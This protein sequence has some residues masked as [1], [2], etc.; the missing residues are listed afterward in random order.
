MAFTDGWDVVSDGGLVKNNVF[1]LI[2]H[3]S[4]QSGLFKNENRRL[5]LALFALIYI[6]ILAISTSYFTILNNSSLI[7]YSFILFILLAV[8]LAVKQGYIS[9]ALLVAIVF[10]AASSV[11][12]TNLL[13]NYVYL[14]AALAVIISALVAAAR[15]NARHKAYAVLF[16][17]LLIVLYGLKLQKL[18]AIDANFAIIGY[19]LLISAVL[20]M[21][22][23]NIDAGERFHGARVWLDSH[24][25]ALWRNNLSV[26]ILLILGII[27]LLL[28]I[29]YAGTRLAPIPL[30]SLPYANLSLYNVSGSGIYL[31]Q[32]NATDYAYLLNANMSNMGFYAIPYAGSEPQHISAFIVKNSTYSAEVP[33]LLKLNSSYYSY[34]IYFMPLEI[35]FENSTYGSVAALNRSA[36]GQIEERAVYIRYS[37]SNVTGNSL[38]YVNKSAS[39]TLPEIKK[40]V[41][42][43]TIEV[44]PFYAM[45]TVCP[46]GSGNTNFTLSFKSNSSISVFFL[47]SLSNYSNAVEDVAGKNYSAC[48]HIFSRLSYISK[49]NSTSMNFSLHLPSDQGCIFYAVTSQNFTKAYLKSSYTYN[50]TAIVNREYKVPK[51]VIAPKKVLK[52]GFVPQSINYVYKIYKSELIANNSTS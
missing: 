20:A 46:Q 27:V 23:G 7:L 43:T 15:L 24:I 19:Y 49:Y 45:Q 38:S 21:I 32:L 36:F 31:I 39:F 26:V 44:P 10:I 3:S 5:I 51:I 12:Y 17:V 11:A 41:S 30:A 13:A 22:I 18:T 25:S 37:A 1:L 50:Y 2:R 9:D 4:S 33:V 14:Y 16:L 42:N 52:F 35:G 29:W 47:G 6:A 8:F 40:V 28:P 48:L 34:R